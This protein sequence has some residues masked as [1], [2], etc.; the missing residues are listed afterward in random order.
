VIPIFW[1]GLLVVLVSMLALDLG[2]F[3]KHP[4]AQTTGEA[5]AW[6]LLWIG[7]ALCFNAFIY[8][9]YENHWMGIGLVVGHELDG[10]QAAIEFFTAYVVE[11]SLSLDNIF[12]IAMI[13]TYFEI[14]LKN[15]HRVLFWG[16]AGALVMRA[17]FIASGLALVS[18]FAWT[19][20]IFG[21]V[22]LATAV[23]MLVERHDNLG[24]EKNALVRVI[25]RHF[26]VTSD[27]H[28]PAFFARR[29]GHRV[30]TPLFLALVVVEAS[31]LLF[32]IDS[33]PAVIAVTRDTFLAFS[34]NAFAILGLRSLYFAIAPLIGRFRLLKL[35]LIFILAF[36]GMKMLL[37][38]HY[39]IP[40]IV[41]LSFILGILGVGISASLLGARRDLVYVATPGERELDRLVRVSLQGARRIAIALIGS[42]ALLLGVAM[43]ILP[44]PGLLVIPIGLALLSTEFVWARRWF[45]RIRK[46]AANSPPC[47][48]VAGSAPIDP[49][50]RAEVTTMPR[51]EP[52]RPA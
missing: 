49:E 42:T 1:I 28:G 37:T 35:S 43:L 23:K 52:S 2:V 10:R 36:V 24:P 39:P 27:F 51:E 38:H 29:K 26:A 7:T 44:G 3:H 30:A 22:L 31:D 18:R 33:I 9:A 12:V 25:E 20:Y 32:A 14:P 50:R 21:A 47:D 8:F 40:T 17:V 19:T 48:A 16:V 11:K 13:F 5:L 45:A 15:Q 41:S 46:A 34:S 4:R 6:S